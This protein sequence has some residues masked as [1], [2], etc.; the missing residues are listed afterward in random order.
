MT[1]SPTVPPPQPPGLAPALARNIRSLS[2]RRAAEERF[3]G[4]QERAALPKWDESFV[5]LGTSA[6]AEAS[7]LS[8]FVLISQNRMAAAADKRADLDLQIS[9]LSEHEVTRLVTLV[10]AIAARM[11]IHTEADAELE[12]LKQD[13]APEVVLDEI[14]AK[15]ASAEAA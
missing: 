6:S 3:A 12:E 8:T 15:T 4:V 10:S 9:L 13:V 1:N 11:D 5:I 2:E 14:E 7:F